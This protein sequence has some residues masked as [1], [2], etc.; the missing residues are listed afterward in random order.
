M[1]SKTEINETLVTRAA[2]FPYVAIYVEFN[3]LKQLYRQGW[4]KRGLPKEQ[5]ESVAEHILGV[6]MLSW[7]ITER[8]FPALNQEKILKMALIHDLGEAY[9][10]DIIPG[11]G[12]TPG[13]KRRRERDG[14]R[15]ILGR[16]ANGQPYIDLWEEYETG[17]TDEARLI[18]QIDRLEMALQA[19]VYEQQGFG[20]LDEFFRSAGE[21]IYT[22]EINALLDA[23]KKL[24]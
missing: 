15:K 8:Y 2:V 10:G 12:V 1:E 17:R 4:L 7:M 13:E 18:H 23:I 3:H 16:L 14:V 24:R 22:P 6:A 19:L 21:S 9:A 11:D 5:C 20:K